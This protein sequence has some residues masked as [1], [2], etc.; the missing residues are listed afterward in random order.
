MGFYNKHILPKIIDYSCKQNSTMRQREKVIPLAKGRVL[1]VGVGSG[2]NLPFYDASKVVQLTALD[3]SEEIWGQN[4]NNIENLGYNFQFIKASAENIPIE[5]NTFDSV[6]ITY[7]L[8]SI[9]DTKKAMGEI[10]RVLKPNGKLIFCE[11]GKAPDK[12][13][14]KWQNAI[15]PV[16]KRFGGGCNLQRDIPMIIEDSKF[17]IKKLETMYLPGWKFASFNYWGMAELS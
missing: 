17:K 12:S 13:V 16:W 5:D 4:K 2:L 7:T 9:P 8:C 14:Q 11:H 6:V 3:P 15:N 10:R 1:E